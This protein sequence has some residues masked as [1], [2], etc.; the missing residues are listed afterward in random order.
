[1]LSRVCR[2]QKGLIGK[3]ECEKLLAVLVQTNTK[4]WKGACRLALED[5]HPEVRSDTNT[6]E[7]RKM[8]RENVGIQKDD[9]EF[10]ARTKSY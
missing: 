1:M 6:D 9:L 8:G 2:T 3:V 5:A 4:I 10:L 7:R